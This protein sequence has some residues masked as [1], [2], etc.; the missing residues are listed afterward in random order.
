MAAL[1]EAKREQREGEDQRADLDRRLLDAHLARLTY[2]GYLVS[3]GFCPSDKSRRPADF[4][5]LTQPE[6]AV[7]ITGTP[8]QYAQRWAQAF[9]QRLAPKA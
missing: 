3:I 1:W 8:E 2:F 7:V 4:R 9:P 6:A 5:L